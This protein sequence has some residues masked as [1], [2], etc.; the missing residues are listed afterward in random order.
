V[1]TQLRN[2]TAEHIFFNQQR[3]RMDN[4]D[5]SS[6]SESWI[7]WDKKVTEKV[8][9]FCKNK[10][11][12]IFPTNSLKYLNIFLIEFDQSAVGAGIFA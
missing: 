9:A 5:I 8:V 10:N 12:N 1:T 6:V 3:Q 7:H 2:R 11:N 4:E